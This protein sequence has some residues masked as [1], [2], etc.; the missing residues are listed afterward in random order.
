MQEECKVSV[1]RERERERELSS[2]RLRRDHGQGEYPRSGYIEHH[3]SVGVKRVIDYAV[4]INV[5]R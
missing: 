3:G 1:A 4:K 5:A 2:D